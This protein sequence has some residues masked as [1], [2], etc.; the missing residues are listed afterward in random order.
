MSAEYLAKKYIKDNNINNLQVSS[1]G[2]IA[3]PELPY[4]HTLERLEK[5]WCN[6][7]KHHQTKLSEAILKDKD[8]IICMA[9]HHLNVVKSFWYCWV[10]FN[11]VAYGK[12]KDVMDDTEY[13]EKYWSLYNLETYVKKIVDY[14]YETMPNVI[15]WLNW[16]EI[17]RKFLIKEIPENI[18][19]YPKK[20][21][22]QWYLKDV[23]DQKIR[24]RKSI[25]NWITE[26]IQTIKKWDWLIRKEYE[27][28]L[29]KKTFYELWKKV[30]NRY[31]EKTRYIL[32]YKKNI[33]ELDI[34]KWE[35]KW[36]ITAE[37]EF[38]NPI[39]AKKFIIPK[40]F[41][42]EIT[43]NKKMTNANLAKKQKI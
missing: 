34:Y 20:K 30:W 22:I 19:S 17:E 37:I 8:F 1:A 39:E 40:R 21:I 3:N 6:A 33:I 27:E 12:K 5:Y 14:I 38:K 41:D 29:S 43:N 7:S 11:F 2:T 4:L 32:P 42:K 36:L 26:Y 15:Q 10:L 24:I 16:F 31:L 23:N 13:Q 28:K 35:F 25:M 9:K 18:E